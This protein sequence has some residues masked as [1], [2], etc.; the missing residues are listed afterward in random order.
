MP[1]KKDA[2]WWRDYRARKAGQTG[3]EMT[4][5]KDL[6]REVGKEAPRPDSRGR[7]SKGLGEIPGSNPPSEEMI[8]Q[9]ERSKPAPKK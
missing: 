8:R 6:S 7:V 5:V 2:Q 4:T 1:G 3:E 9:W